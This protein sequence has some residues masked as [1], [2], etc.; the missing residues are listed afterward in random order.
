MKV[1]DLQIYRSRKAIELL[2][3]RI[4][5]IALSSQANA[6]VHMKLYFKEWLDKTQAIA[7]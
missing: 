2:E 5:E 1:V 4:G 3:Q 7:Q 6:A